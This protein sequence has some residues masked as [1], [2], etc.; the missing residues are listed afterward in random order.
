MAY[1]K[2]TGA[3]DPSVLFSETTSLEESHLCL[4]IMA[5]LNLCYGFRYADGELLYRFP[6]LMPD[7]TLPLPK[8]NPAFVCHGISFRSK[9]LPTG[10]YTIPFPS[11]VFY[12]LQTLLVKHFEIPPLNQRMARHECIV[13][14]GEEFCYARLEDNHDVI[15]VFVHAEGG[16]FL[17]QV[18]KV[19]DGKA[20]Y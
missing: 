6:S 1:D 11:V 5:Q 15:T 4:G 13:A 16:S 17:A 9:P 12:K 3:V 14:Q 10:N 7:A 8:L 20:S 18:K 19:I 2:N